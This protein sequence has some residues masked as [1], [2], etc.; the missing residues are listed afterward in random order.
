MSNSD[1]NAMT[2]G[3]TTPWKDY[4]S[5]ELDRFD[6][7]DQVLFVA[8]D[9]TCAFV[10]PHHGASCRVH[11]ADD[12][13]LNDIWRKHRLVALLPVFRSIQSAH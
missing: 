11:H 2:T 1:I 8:R 12:R 6:L 5:S 13:E 9:R 7:G 3:F 4:T 10:G